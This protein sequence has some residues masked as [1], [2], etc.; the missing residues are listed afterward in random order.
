MIVDASGVQLSI[1]I[2]AGESIRL[3][4]EELPIWPMTLD[5]NN[6]CITISLSTRLSIASVYVISMF[7]FPRRLSLM[8][9]QY[10]TISIIALLSANGKKN[11][12]EKSLWQSPK[13]CWLN[14]GF[15]SEVFE[16]VPYFPVLRWT[17]SEFIL[18]ILRAFQALKCQCSCKGISASVFSTTTSSSELSCKSSSIVKYLESSGI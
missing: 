17:Q 12:K 7:L 15:Q 18:T 13:W 9:I 10:L 2:S 11:L 14:S 4:K 8:L 6:S 16:L 1:W 3:V 5:N